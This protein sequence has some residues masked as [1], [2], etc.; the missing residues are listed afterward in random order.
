MQFITITIILGILLC[1]EGLQRASN[2]VK[3][4]I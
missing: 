2:K 4:K 3:P 1:V